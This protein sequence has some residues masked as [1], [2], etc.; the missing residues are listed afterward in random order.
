MTAGA[1]TH[2]LCVL[3]PE[4][5]LR[6]VLCIHAQRGRDEPTAPQHHAPAPQALTRGLSGEFC[7][8]DLQDRPYL[9]EHYAPAAQAHT[10]CFTGKYCI[11]QVGADNARPFKCTCSNLL[12]S[13]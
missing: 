2:P 13:Y 3:T 9:Y 5:P 6:K 4:L 1:P 7:C 11:L 12:F 8:C 10:H